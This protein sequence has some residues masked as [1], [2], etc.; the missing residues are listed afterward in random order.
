MLSNKLQVLEEN[1]TS[2]DLIYPVPWA[3]EPGQSFAS[4]SQ[5]YIDAA[6]AAGFELVQS[7]HKREE[8]IAFAKGVPP[9]GPPPLSLPRVTFGDNG[10][11][12]MKNIVHLIKS[13]TITP[14]EMIFK[15]SL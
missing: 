1:K 10:M 8:G 5:V 6:A 13:E 15:K 2:D 9:S 3:T 7:I 4:H 14:C 12:K 11:T